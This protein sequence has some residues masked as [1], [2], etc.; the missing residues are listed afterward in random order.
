M[1]RIPPP[2]SGGIHIVCQWGK[3][4]LWHWRKAR[5]P[6]M[7]DSNNVFYKISNNRRCRE[8][9]WG[10]AR[11]NGGAVKT[12]GIDI[13]SYP[14]PT[15][16]VSPRNPVDFPLLNTTRGMTSTHSQ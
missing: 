7:V 6:N 9:T 1:Q 14:I 2:Y 4:L 3:H 12:T 16:H 8:R 10:T 11:Y 15:G 13:A 5:R